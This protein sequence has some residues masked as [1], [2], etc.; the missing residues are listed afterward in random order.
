MY[1]QSSSEKQT[2]NFFLMQKMFLQGKSACLQIIELV[3]ERKYLPAIVFSFSKKECEFYAKQVFKLRFNSG[4]FCDKFQ[5][6]C[7]KLKELL[8]TQFNMHC[9]ILP[10]NFIVRLKIMKKV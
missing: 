2:F 10:F 5:F 4:Q 8:K 1:P 3:M 9:N 7:K 6:M